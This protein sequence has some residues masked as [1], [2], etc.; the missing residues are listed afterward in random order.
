MVMGEL[1]LNVAVIKASDDKQR[2][3]GRHIIRMRA[4]YEDILK[5][6]NRYSSRVQFLMFSKSAL[7]GVVHRHLYLLDNGN[8]DP[9]GRPTVPRA[10]ILTVIGLSEFVCLYNY[11]PQPEGLLCDLG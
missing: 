10:N 5:E 3:A 4:C 11:A 1:R 9:D 8:D 2:T 6:K 7:R